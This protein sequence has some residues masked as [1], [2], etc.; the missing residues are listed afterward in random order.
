MQS[1]WEFMLSLL[2]ADKRTEEPVLWDVF[3]SIRRKRGYDCL[4]IQLSQPKMGLHL[5]HGFQFIHYL[6][7]F[8]LH[9]VF[10]FRSLFLNSLIYIISYL[11]QFIQTGSDVILHNAAEMLKMGNRSAVFGPYNKCLK[12]KL[13]AHD[14]KMTKSS[15]IL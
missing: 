11:K 5:T 9:F 1:T 8:N 13:I 7:T 2:L 15:G 4:Q 6:W 3:D 10:L 12:P 14:N